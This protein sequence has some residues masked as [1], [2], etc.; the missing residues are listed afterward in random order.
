MN[1]KRKSN[2]QPE[3]VV[4]AAETGDGDAI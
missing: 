4:V 3:V 2:N 1:K